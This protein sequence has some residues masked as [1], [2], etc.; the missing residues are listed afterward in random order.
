MIIL[1]T[2]PM[3][4][5]EPHSAPFS[6]IGAALPRPL[7]IKAVVTDM[8]G[9]LMP[10]YKVLIS[11][12]EADAAL[13][14]LFDG[15]YHKMSDDTLPVLLMT[16][17]GIQS[18]LHRPVESTQQMFV[19]TLQE[20]N[21]DIPIVT[22]HRMHQVVSESFQLYDGVL[23]FLI[24]A[25]NCGIYIAIYS[26]S[27]SG[28]VTSRLLRSGISPI[29]FNAIYAKCIP[30]QQPLRTSDSF[31][32]EGSYEKILTPYAFQKP[33][34]TPLKQI[35][36]ITKATPHQILM[37]GDGLN[38]LQVAVGIDSS[39]KYE[40]GQTP[41]T[42]IFC[43]QEEGANDISNKELLMNSRLRPGKEVL[44]AEAVNREIAALGVED[45]IIRLPQGFNTL[46]RLIKDGAIRL[47]P[48]DDLGDQRSDQE[49][50]PGASGL[51]HLVFT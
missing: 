37:I 28:F 29:Y 7:H 15:M 46:I 27:L 42:S 23:D 43:F 51:G 36:H 19:H 4:I 39:T 10:T 45:Q 3:V 14:S 31:P 30:G 5:T 1:T 9:T 35:A 49:A 26:S 41:H 6:D 33:D 13:E 11:I 32:V 25:A 34:V 2:Q 47:S 12:I 40:S 21:I 16:L 17:F 24:R 20:L 50:T 18:L 48:S 8:D 22:L 38:D 44:G